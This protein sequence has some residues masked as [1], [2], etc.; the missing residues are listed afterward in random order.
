M[1]VTGK[2]ASLDKQQFYI[3]QAE[4]CK[5]MANPK[6]LEIIALISD[7]AMCVEEIARTMGVHVPNISQH[8][9][10]L[11]DKRVVDVT[12]DGTRLYYRL[13]DPH[14]IEACDMMRQ[15]VIGRMQDQ[16]DLLK[17]IQEEG[18]KVSASPKK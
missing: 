17:A 8:L 5:L 16:A 7:R 3:E 10:M 2:E 9:A 18:G 11:R 12:R 4:F 6:R 14:L 13:S 15:A 1:Q